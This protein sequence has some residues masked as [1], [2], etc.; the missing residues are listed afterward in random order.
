MAQDNE[1]ATTS[2]SYYS[3][4][5][6]SRVTKRNAASYVELLAEQGLQGS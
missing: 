4:V 5:L 6:A 2:T 1:I 3:I